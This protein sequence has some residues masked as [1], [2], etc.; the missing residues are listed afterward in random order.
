MPVYGTHG[1]KENG[2]A[3]RESLWIL[4]GLPFCALR[5]VPGQRSWPKLGS[6][7]GQ[8]S[9]RTQLCWKHRDRVENCAGV[10]FSGAADSLGQE[11]VQ[12]FSV[13]LC[14]FT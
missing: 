9:G 6:V 1:T 14:Q 2:S 13:Q 4:P 10:E 8:L 11:G 5:G 3:D 12:R 7:R